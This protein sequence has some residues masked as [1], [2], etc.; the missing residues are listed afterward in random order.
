MQ[1]IFKFSLVHL[2]GR[3]PSKAELLEG[4]DFE[5]ST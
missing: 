1:G 3:L 2:L 4:A 5:L